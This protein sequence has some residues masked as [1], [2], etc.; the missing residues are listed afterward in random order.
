MLPE[1]VDGYVKKVKHFISLAEASV[2]GLAPGRCVFVNV[3]MY[4]VEINRRKDVGVEIK[5]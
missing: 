4:W 5:R 1:P 2:I 3:N